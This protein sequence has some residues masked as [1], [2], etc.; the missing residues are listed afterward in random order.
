MTT[1]RADSIWIDHK[2]DIIFIQ[3]HM[4]THSE[5][6]KYHVTGNGWTLATASARKNSDNA[7]IGSVGMLIGPLTLKSLNSI[8]K[9]QPRMMVATFNGNSRATII[10]CY[11]PTNV[12]EETDL[13]AFYDK[14]YSLVCSIPKYH[15]LV[16]GRDMNAQIG[17]NVYHKFSSHNFC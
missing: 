3:E 9:I 13:I 11:S 14:L 15:V 10:S 8:K 5:D 6:I 2:I 4:Y 16:I 17:K 7:M 12:N 1:S